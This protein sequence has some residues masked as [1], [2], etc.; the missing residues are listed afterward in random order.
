[1]VNRREFLGITASAGAALALT[2]EL[3]RALQA[4]QQPGRTL[5]QRAIPSSGEMLPAVGLSFSNHVGCADHAALREVLKTFAGNGGRVFDAQHGNAAAEQFHATVADEVG[6][7]NTLFWSTRGTPPAGPGGPP[8]LGPDSVKAHV[9]TLL[10]RLKTAKL[11]LVMLPPQGDPMHLAAL[12][13]E[14]RAGRVRYIGVQVIGDPVYPQLEA[15]MRT[16]PIDF[17]GVDYDIGNRA[18]VEDT[19]LPLAQERK[20]GVMA[21]FP[22]GNNGGIS[23]GGTSRN[24]FARVG[25]RPL[26]AWAAEFDAKTW[27]QFFL[28]YVISHPA[29]TVARVG[30]TKAT[31]M[32]D[33]MG[34]GVGRL[35]DEAT[36]KRMAALI[37][38]LPALP[39]PP[40]N[41]AAA[42]GIALPVAVLDRYVG[43]YKAASGLA[44]T[45]RRDGE[46]LFVKPGTNP[47][48]PL[49]ARSETRF[50]DP[51]G[52]VFEF[53]LD[54]QGKVTGAVLEQQG[55]QG[56]QRVPL[57]RK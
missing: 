21:F 30:T 25:N 35:P 45:I 50:Q 48:A 22:L 23:C 37:D 51:R 3:L 13:E 39:P 36:R 32:L 47:E 1:M 18:R 19:I 7:Q 43:E 34:G 12:Q 15:V 28:K 41:P 46:R 2:P 5:I 20:I 11:D 38:A 42:P 29:V 9:A 33:N 31:H 52:P 49:N 26:P 16:A 44:V 17:I 57:A 6:I 56:P 53:Q 24:L 14:K 54:G 27:A 40:Q 55:P 4:L 8:Q 10:A